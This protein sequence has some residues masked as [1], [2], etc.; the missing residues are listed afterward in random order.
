[1]LITITSLLHI[2][3]C[4]VAGKAIR[5]RVLTVMR[6]GPH[7]AYVFSYFCFFFTHAH[8]QGGK[9]IGRDVV[10]VIQKITTSRDSGI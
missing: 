5:C 2:L 8:T 7:N 6:L 3:R 1:M 10:V 9:V 4:L